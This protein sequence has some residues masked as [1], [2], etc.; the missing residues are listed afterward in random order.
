MFL[1]TVQLPSVSAASDSEAPIYTVQYDNGRSQ[2]KMAYFIRCACHLDSD[3]VLGPWKILKHST[4]V[5]QKI[6]KSAL[7]CS[8]HICVYITAMQQY[9]KITTNTSNYV[10]PS[11]LLNREGTLS[12]SVWWRTANFAVLCH[13]ACIKFHR[14]WCHRR[15]L[16]Q[17]CS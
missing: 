7:N 1:A 5:S 8:H 10:H 16:P 11:V 2:K 12:S 9:R 14:L 15:F 4:I 6:Q 13:L 3:S 17:K